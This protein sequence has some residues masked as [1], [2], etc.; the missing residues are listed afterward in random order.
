MTLDD[1]LGKHT[2]SGIDLYRKVTNYF[3]EEAYYDGVNFI[4]DN[5]TIVVLED[6]SD[7]YRSYLSNLE[8]TNVKVANTFEPVN[9]HGVKRTI[10]NWGETIVK[11]DSSLIDLIDDVTNKV[12]L[13]LGTDYYTDE[14]Y[15]CCIMEFHPENMIINKNLN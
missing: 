1:L 9:V 15:P 14:Y 2:F 10:N 6:P 4:L 3:G 13:S 7:G 11:E 12:V 5:E 8:H